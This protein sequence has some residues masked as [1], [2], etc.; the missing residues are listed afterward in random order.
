MAIA[1][2]RK[3]DP[4]ETQDVRHAEALLT[5]G[6]LQSAIFNSANF[7]SIATDA[8]GVIQI[9][10]VGA[11][12]MLGYTAAEVM[13]KITPADISDPQEVIARA[14]ELSV[15][16][17]TPITP[18]FEALVFK[19]SRGIEDIY[20][21]T[22]IR[23]DRSRFPA[24]VSVTAL[25]D[26]QD[27]IIGYLL[28]GTDNTARKRA[29]EALLKAG[30]LQS[31][32]F[33]SA[34]F[35]S[36][37]TDANG[38]IQ[39]FN[40]GAERMLGYAAADVMNK[41]T[42]ADISDPQEVIAR[43][44][45][46][47]VELGTPITPGF[48]ALVF[49]A[50]RG[51]EDIYELT[52][53]R[54]DGSRFPAVVSVTALRDDQD[55]IIGYLLIGT[56]NTARKKAE[57]ALLQAGALQSAIFNSA[58]FSSIATD[59]KGVIQIF[60]V[61]A[62]RMLG[63]T[64]A[65]VMNKNTPADISDSAEIVA[66]AKALSVEFRSNI[67]PG[68]EALVFKA[69]RGIEDIYELTYIRK[70]GSRFPAVVSVTALRD[71]QDAIIGY[72]LIGTD[73]TARKKAE[74][75]LLQ[76]GALQSAIFNSANFSSIATDAK[77]VI[78]IF[79]VGAEKMLGFAAADVMNKITPADI[80][81]SQEIVARAKAL[82]VEFGTPIAPGFE[83]LVFKASRGIED[84]YELTYIRKDGSRFPAVVSVTALRDDK[85]GGGI[86][87]YLLI[88]TDN[89][90][91]KKAEEALLQAGALQSAIFNSA[92]FSSIATD[93]KGVIQ[94]FNVGAER[95]LGY[96]AADVMNKNT[97]ADI[98]DSAEIVARAKA[99][100][101]E[102][103]SNITPGFEALV[104]KASRGIEDIYE[105]TYIRKDGSRFPAVVSVTALR[106]AQ[107]AII[108]YLLIGTDN[109]ARKKAEEALLQA[110]A[111]Q[112]AIFNSANFSSIATDAK[113]VIQIFNVGAE[114]M[115]G[116]AAAD[117]MNKKNPADISDP[118]ELIARAKTLSV[119]FGTPIA[120]G[121][122]ALVFKASRGIED[123]YE[124]TYIR[125]DGSRFPAVV[126]V[127]ALRDDKAGGGIIGYL[128]IGTDNT[129]RKQAEEALLKAGALQSAIFNSANFSSIATDAKGVIQIFN[130]GAERM[131]G[132]T[133]AEVMNK[134]TPADISDPQEVISRAKALSV[135]L[136]TPITPGFEALV[137]KAS[138]GIE[139][140]YE[141]TY[142]RKDGSRFPAVVSV[143]ALRDDQDAIIG[144]LL[145]GT[146]NTARKQVEE[147]R[148]K[149]DQRLRDQ[150]FYTRSLI[151][152][153]IDALMT[154]DPRGIIT[155]VNKQTEAL[156]GCT[157]DELIG[158]PF[159]NYFTDSARAE[160]GINRVLS[161][162][163]VTNYELT[164]RARDGHLTV[165]S[166]NAT[167]FHDRDRRLQG[168]FAAA[169]DMTELKR[170]EQTLQLKNVELED[171]SRMKSEFLANM[172]HEL[173]TPLNAIIGFSE[174]LGDG[175]LG[176]MTD[177]QRKFIGDI[178]SSGKH[179][180]SLINDI[181]DLSKVEAGKMQLDVEPVEVS[182]LFANS[183]SIIKGQ[184]ATR[185]LRLDME[186][187]PGLGSIRADARKVKQ[188]VYN[189]LSNAVKFSS[190]GGQVTLRASRVLRAEVGQLTGNWKGR[191]TAL[192]D[193]DFVEFLKISVTDSGIG[194]SPD[195]L[196]ALFK[197]FSQVDSGLARKFEGTGLG[198]A[199]VKLLAELHGGAVAVE[200]A[201]HE[202]SRFTV[203]VPLRPA[204]EVE[205]T[206][207]KAL[208]APHVDL[209][210]GTR[211]AL[212]VEDDYK[213]A[214]LI[215]VQLEAEGFTVLHA[216]T[217]EDALTLAVQQPLALITLDIMLP[218]M[219]GWEFLSRLKAMPELRHIPVVIISIVADQTK[220][221][222]LGAAAVMQKPI[223]RLE[224]Y[225]SLVQLG[226]FPVSHG[227]TLKVL[228]VDDDPKAVELIA[229]RMQEWAS[230]VL[231]AY[232]GAEAIEIA[233]RE[234]P[235]LL[236][237]DLMMPDV[238]GF[239]VVDAL[240]HDPN[241]CD[242]PILVVTAKNITAADRR[243][244]DGYV[245]TIMEKGGFDADRFATEVRRA[246]SGRHV[247][248]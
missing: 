198:L 203:W 67:T 127:T 21:L 226:L 108:G 62:E 7:S 81:D 90:A 239:D 99:L 233:R 92:N 193:N 49:K 85:D 5:T 227:K 53:I 166:Y 47:S 66:R 214:D 75:A 32:I 11:E 87:G 138:R 116:Y 156:T 124:L 115:L 167:T 28:I 173:R 215:R 187:E 189:L 25:R 224:L 89:T 154:T 182:S 142:I 16:F 150:H 162:G 39:I 194:I 234:R 195:G 10:N 26:A 160:A 181:L 68:F 117:V 210:G 171:A 44:K 212:V 140:I 168:V 159:K 149:L 22:Y 213:S 6:A 237:L 130:V 228:V 118:Q 35:S 107:D 164:A 207:V 45:A 235:D 72:L 36:I 180:L 37:A 238:S 57:E 137:F 177:Q 112:S 38:V 179:L 61:G 220:G 120:P 136:G 134:N 65:D 24:V 236:V 63:Y 1:S 147:E 135:E 71:A 188:I 221:V 202:G 246:M 59:A 172:S 211:T 113:G 216:G 31:A 51:I 230:T 144:Y 183:L 243:R 163:T 93:A 217:A 206:T 104:F 33:N 176:D 242:V 88:G 86:I 205:P 42:P 105:L 145:I 41:I 218:K 96:T 178:F 190:E 148:Q 58:N 48:E 15:E 14:K 244:L 186:V 232:G 101:V 34:N 79:N 13:N 100:S 174:V 18:G 121:F 222:A 241:T 27:V 240:C 199:M 139:D 106:D 84:I 69:S 12:R 46:L 50:S 29:E 95:M 114:K 197:P 123:I 122:E 247:D 126:S 91:R 119:E 9:F 165:V 155:D 64:A 201:V 133:A 175:L 20:E 170:Y 191:T 73:N 158:A 55:A 74:E 54:K 185:H 19:A 109:T 231:R 80:S 52:Y 30:A 152:S 8:K 43:A 4:I 204:E 132:Y 196:E 98:S 248:V 143:T 157:R 83:A 2:K 110:G 229:V 102:F 125:K 23:K 209:T 94:I 151:E 245:T 200:S 131:L 153:N 192:A 208:A 169:R 129:A 223:S 56:D 97:P 70:D 76:A 40:V 219:D 141:L 3:S 161:E 146:D 60:N 128:L 111:L 103:R 78:Q 82:S 77:G 184:A 17:G 225:E